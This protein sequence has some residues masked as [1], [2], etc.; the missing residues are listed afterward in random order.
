MKLEPPSGFR[1]S[2]TTDGTYPLIV[3]PHGNGGPMRYFFVLFVLAWFC[4]WTAVFGSLALQLLSALLSGQILSGQTQAF[5][6][7]WLVAWI[8][9]GAYAMYGLYRTLW[10]SVPESLTLM[11]NSVTYDFGIP[12]LQFNFGY[13]FQ[14]EAWNCMFPKRRRMELDRRQLQS[15]RLRETNDGNRLT[16]DVDALRLDIGQSA[17]EIE[18]EW[19]HQL[20][21][22]HYSLSSGAEIAPADHGPG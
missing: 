4:G 19:L 14:K 6:V 16:V 17:S 10:P 21:A 13:K 7:F 9:G 18:R 12:P 5:L 11:P 1:I 2:L 8:L 22:N 15:L 20:L 3:I